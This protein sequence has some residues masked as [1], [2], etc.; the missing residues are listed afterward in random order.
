MIFTCLIF[1]TLSLKNAFFGIFNLAN[2]LQRGDADVPLFETKTKSQR[3][4]TK[5]K[6]YRSE[7]L[8]GSC[9]IWLRYGAVKKRQ[10]NRRKPPKNCKKNSAGNGG[11]R[12]LR[13]RFFTVPYG[14]P[15]K[16]LPCKISD[17]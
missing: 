7:I 9:F 4:S 16:Q 5:K 14:T 1:N 2:L 6:S 3:N 13:R 8:H 17:L 12:R 10:R 15:I 11:F